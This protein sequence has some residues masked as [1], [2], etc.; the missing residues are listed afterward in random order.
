M[1][2]PV[3]ALA[4]FVER[5]I[6]VTIEGAPG[7]TAEFD[8][9]RTIVRIQNAGAPY[10]GVAQVVLYGL[11]L[12]H[13]N[14]LST[15]AFLYRPQ[16]N[17]TMT[18]EAGDPV[19]GMGQVFKGTIQQAWG[20][21]TN[22]PDVAFHISAFGSTAPA[23]VG[24]AE[25]TSAS[26]GVDVVPLIRTL[27]KQGGLGFRNYGVSKKLHNVYHWGSPWKQI[28][29]LAVA[30][31]INVYV[32]NQTCKIWPKSSPISGNFLVKAGLNMRDYPSFTMNGV[33]VKIEYSR[34][35]EFGS[36]I[37]V[38]SDLRDANGVWE[39]IRL[40]YDLAAELPGG[41]WFV[42]AEAKKAGDPNV[43][44]PQ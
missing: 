37:T 10:A 13:I 31:N 33:F 8:G 28:Y 5:R 38:E 9:L 1:A 3:G 4:L 12:S 11:S 19:N 2:G 30:S 24:P 35:I 16:M 14:D 44:Y 32:E 15:K 18:I 29:E 23:Q 34:P 20:D 43:R 26:G 39:L 7:G 41:N 17:F 36:S 6:K 27:C 25:P 40:D 21:F 42:Y 22:M